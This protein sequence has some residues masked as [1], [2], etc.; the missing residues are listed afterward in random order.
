MTR[1]Y[2]G[3]LDCRAC[4]IYRVPVE[5]DSCTGALFG[6][7]GH[8][9]AQRTGMMSAAPGLCLAHNKKLFRTVD[10]RVS[11]EAAYRWSQLG[12]TEA[13]VRDGRTAESVYFAPDCSYSRRL[14]RGIM[15][16]SAG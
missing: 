6:G 2:E 1:R 15:D 12:P 7:G 11:T 8:V 5:G 3:A 9:L 10:Y 4:P 13:S 16:K 14:R